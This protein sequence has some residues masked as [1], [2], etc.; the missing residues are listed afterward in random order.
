M[1]F[2]VLYNICRQKRQIEIAFKVFKGF[3]KKKGGTKLTRFGAVTH[4]KTP[5]GN[6]EQGM[7]WGLHSSVIKRKIIVQK[8]NNRGQGQS[9]ARTNNV[10]CSIIKLFG[11]LK[12]D[13]IK[14]KRR[15]NVLMLDN[16]ASEPIKCSGTTFY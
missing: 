4:T 16:K 3:N 9:A 11:A 1:G 10:F 8:L 12:M 13:K 7:G 2:E 14:F 6:T 5:T 15:S